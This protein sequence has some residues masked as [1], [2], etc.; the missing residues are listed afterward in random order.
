MQVSRTAPISTLY[1]G[2]RSTY[3]YGQVSGQGRPAG[4]STPKDHCGLMAGSESA[5]EARV[6]S[7][8][9]AAGARP[10]GAILPMTGHCPQARGSDYPMRLTV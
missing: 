2:A 9:I 6:E 7:G 1:V 3:G 5:R 10:A 4:Y 8:A